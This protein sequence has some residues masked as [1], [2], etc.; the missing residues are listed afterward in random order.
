MNQEEGSSFAVTLNTWAHVA[1]TFSTT[2]GNQSYINGTSVKTVSATTGRPIGPYTILGV[3]PM[4]TSSYNAGS[5][6]MGQFYGN[7]DEYRVFGRELTSTDICRS[8]N[9]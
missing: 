4:N 3:S 7:I 9:P 6:L 8:A 5:I 1:Q 2:N